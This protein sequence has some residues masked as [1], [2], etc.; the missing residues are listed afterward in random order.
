MIPAS[1]QTTGYALAVLSALCLGVGTFIY[2]LSGKHLS[3]SNTTFFYYLFSFVLA[4]VVWIATPNRGDVTKQALV[5]PALM[6]VFLCISVWTFSS[7]TRA[8]DMST[9]STL[10][11]LSFLPTVL[12]SVLIFH[13]KPSPK[14]L[15]AMLLIIIAVLL[16]GWDASE[17]DEKGEG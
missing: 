16:L 15:V 6:A 8:I 9:A 13:E 3:A 5:W 4:S 10:R 2:K 17:V 14:A 7:P 12:L 1:P 11:G